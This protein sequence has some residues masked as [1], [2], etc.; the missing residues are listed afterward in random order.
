MVGR[1]LSFWDGIFSGVML[2]FQ[3]HPFF[4]VFF[5]KGSSCLEWISRRYFCSLPQISSLETSD[6]VEWNLPET[7]VTSPRDKWSDMGP[8]S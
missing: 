6:L 4:L 8:Y 3:G 2:N 7:G 1:L 5:F